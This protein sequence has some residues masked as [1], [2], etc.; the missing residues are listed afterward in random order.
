[1]TG[2]LGQV[3]YTATSLDPNAKVFISVNGKLLETLGGEG[4]ELEQPL[5]RSSF[6]KNFPL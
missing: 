3:I 2:R 4:L 6:Q 1:M 5:T